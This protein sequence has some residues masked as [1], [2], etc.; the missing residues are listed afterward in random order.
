MS[1][2]VSVIMPVYN[3]EKFIQETIESI[4][5]QT[6]TD[7]ELII[8]DDG[9]SDRTKAIIKSIDDSRIVLVEHNEKEVL[10]LLE[11]QDTPRQRE[12]TLPF[13]IQMIL[14]YLID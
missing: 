8:V 7:F 14:I 10:P 12:S 6:Y 1:I 13:L 9:S 4:L 11:I 5:N 2:I 3:R